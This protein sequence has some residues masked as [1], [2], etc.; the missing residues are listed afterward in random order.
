LSVPK[1]VLSLAEKSSEAFQAIL[2]A[3]VRYSFRMIFAILELRF[4]LELSATLS[5]HGHRPQYVPL[6]HWEENFG[7]TA[8]RADGISD[9]SIYKQQWLPL[10][11]SDDSG[12]RFAGLNI[13]PAIDI[14]AAGSILA[15]LLNG[16]RLFA[17]GDA[18]DRLD[19]IHFVLG[20]TAR[21]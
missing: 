10:R 2:I 13:G 12:H 14:W 6:I 5:I 16:R 15:G 18:T 3:P 19:G 17:G 7:H 20:L 4:N 1:A 9:Y 8:G 21:R 11:V